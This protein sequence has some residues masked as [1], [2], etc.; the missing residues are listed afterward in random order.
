MFSVQFKE[1]CISS[2]FFFFFFFFGGGGGYICCYQCCVYEVCK[3]SNLVIY[4]HTE[5]NMGIHS[6]SKLHGNSSYDTHFI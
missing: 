5:K 3:Y 2:F 4:H 6:S 1:H